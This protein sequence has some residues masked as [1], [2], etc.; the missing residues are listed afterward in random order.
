MDRHSDQQWT[1]QWVVQQ[2]DTQ[3]NK[4]TLRNI[5]MHTDRQRQN[6]QKYKLT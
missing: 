1:E 6:R 4:K 2:I 3:K 5:F